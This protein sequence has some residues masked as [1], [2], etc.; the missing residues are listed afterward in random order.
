MEEIQNSGEQPKA[1]SCENVQERIVEEGTTCSQEVN[2]SL[3][4]F[5]DAESLL[6]A[7]NN[8]QA[9]FTRKCQ[10]LSQL[11]KLLGENGGQND[12]PISLNKSQNLSKNSENKQNNANFNENNGKSNQNIISKTSIIHL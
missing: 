12:E 8:L 4:K 11:Q 2:G 6:S 3:G 10:K 9:E 1:N 7:Y 5:K